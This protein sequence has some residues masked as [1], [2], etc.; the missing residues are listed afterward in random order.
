METKI[1]FATSATTKTGDAVKRTIRVL[2]I[3]DKWATTLDA[4]TAQKSY[5]FTDD[6]LKAVNI[7]D[8]EMEFAEGLYNSNKFELYDVV[9]TKVAPKT[10]VTKAKPITP[11]EL[12]RR[13]EQRLAQ[14]LIAL[15][16]KHGVVLREPLQIDTNGEYCLAVSN[17]SVND[18]PSDPCGDFGAL[19]KVL[20]KYRPRTGARPS[21]VYS[22]DGWCYMNHFDVEKM[23][24]ENK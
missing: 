17:G 11:F 15:A 21:K 5:P 23:I 4:L 16:K 3:G 10:K 12:G 2:K 7:K 14:E 6:V 24:E 8:A 19:A 20:S 13:R 1:S 22:Y 9:I 18:G